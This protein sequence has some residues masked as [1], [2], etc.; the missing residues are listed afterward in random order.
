MGHG[1]EKTVLDGSGM[2]IGVVAARWNAFV[3]EPLLLGAQEALQSCGVTDV[4]IVR[5]PGAFE[6]PCAANWLCRTGEFDA[7]IVLGAVIRGDT[8]HFEFVA[9]ECARGVQDVM[10]RTQVPVIFGV[11][12]TNTTDQATSRA[13]IAGDNK[14]AEA[15]RAAIEMAIVR[16]Q[17]GRGSALETLD[18]N[19][20][21]GEQP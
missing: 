7:V 21:F 9:G 5:V 8:A 10:L 3:V 19:R 6:L 16:R 11:L 12:T 17:W 2:C 18:K 15:A 14:G 13:D 1:I 20:D 4:H